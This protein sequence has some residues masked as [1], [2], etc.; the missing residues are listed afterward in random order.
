MAVCALWM[1]PAGL[2][3]FLMWTALAGGVLTFT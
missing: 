2:A 1:G 3:P